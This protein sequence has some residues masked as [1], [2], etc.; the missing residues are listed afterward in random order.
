[1]DT[2]FWWGNL[3]QRVRLVDLDIDGN[4]VFKCRVESLDYICFVHDR[5]KCWH[6]L[7]TCQHWR[8]FGFHKI[9]GISGLAEDLVAPQ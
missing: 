1:V 4:I 7:I 5:G 2:G 3:K 9:Q 6:V 8:N